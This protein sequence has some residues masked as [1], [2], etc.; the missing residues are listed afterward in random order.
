M[1]RANMGRGVAESGDSKK[2]QVFRQHASGV[3]RALWPADMRHSL[4]TSRVAQRRRKLVIREKWWA[5]LLATI[6]ASTALT[7]GVITL[8]V[9]GSMLAALVFHA[10]W[11]LLFPVTILTILSL[12]ITP[13][14]LIKLKQARRMGVAQH[15]RKRRGT[16]SISVAPSIRRAPETPIPTSPL[17]RELET[18]DLSQT[19]VEH[20]LASSGKHN[21]VRHTFR[22]G[23][24]TLEGNLEEMSQP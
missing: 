19:D 6:E 22:M 2:L 11:L 1:S 23:K 10:W 8:C 15:A 16:S 7:M 4:A 21:A 14:L 13:P 24:D 12:A 20:F 17:V 3:S 18:F 9:G 5:K